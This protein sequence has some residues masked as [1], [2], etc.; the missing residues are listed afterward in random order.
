[1]RL[2]FRDLDQR[3]RDA[4]RLATDNQVRLGVEVSKE[5][6]AKHGVRVHDE[7]TFFST[8]VYRTILAIALLTAYQKLNLQIKSML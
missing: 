5:A 4:V 1:M 6:V 3:A 8:G 7:D 2:A